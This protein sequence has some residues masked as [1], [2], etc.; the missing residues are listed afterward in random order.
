MN[1][2]TDT[3]EL[4]T[5]NTNAVEPEAVIPFFAKASKLSGLQLRTRIRAGLR[6]QE[7]N[8]K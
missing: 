8:E 7:H 2:K 1:T 6:K 3:T 4:K 5:E